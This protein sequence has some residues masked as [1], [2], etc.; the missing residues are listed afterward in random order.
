MLLEL[1]HAKIHRATITDACLHYQGSI[2]V[3]SALLARAGMRVHQRVQVLNLNNG[4]RFET[5]LIAEPADS[6]AV[7]V[8][9]AAARLVQKGDLVILCTYCQVEAR[10]AEHHQPTV[11]LMDA[12]NRLVS[13]PTATMPLQEPV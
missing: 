4:E 3:D 1:L 2:G 6:G 12:G 9:G 13:A 10:E 7:V 8:N 11:L 5:Y